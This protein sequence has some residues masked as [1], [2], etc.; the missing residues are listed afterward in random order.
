MEK[1]FERAL[2]L[3]SNRNSLFTSLGEILNELSL[4]VR[5]YDINGE[6]NAIGNFIQAQSLRLPYSLRQR[7]EK[8]FQGKL[9]Q[10]LL[11]YIRKYNPDLVLVYNSEFLLPETCY[12]IKKK[13]KLVFYLADSPFYTPQNNF[14]LTVLSLADLIL[15]PDTF[16]SKQ[17]NT[18]GLSR[19]L[20][21]VPG[22]D[23][24][25]F[26]RLTNESDFREVTE[27]EVLYVGSSYFNS[28]GYKKALLMSKFVDLDFQLHGN[29]MWKR[30]FGYFP[31][32]KSKYTESG[33]IPADKLN[34]MF[35][36]AKVIPV[37]GNP[38]ILNGFHL[39]VFEALST[40]ALP[41]IEEREDVEQSLFQGCAAE[42]P[43]IRN[44][45]T[46]AEV[47]RYFLNNEQK[48]EET[49]NTLMTFVLGKYNA[50]ANAEL[51]SSSL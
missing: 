49:V 42:I 32:L 10:D 5:G 37:D 6:I 24:I 20:Y 16:W 47:A 15:S 48:R 1:R 34:K 31:E 45:N 12:L 43:L 14:Y 4:E 2:L 30:W 29:K 8:A 44:Y 3:C 7:W 9:N 25:N 28:W 41:L 40:G 38:G 35:N 23:Q 13:A 17:L 46:A 19:T 33:Y 26:N 11:L 18:V 36:K 27:T 39:R 22:P 51:L 21:Y 50:T